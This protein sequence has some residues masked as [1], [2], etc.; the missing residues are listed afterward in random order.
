M[1]PDVKEA[2]GVYVGDITTSPNPD[3][4]HFGQR[5][6]RAF[7]MNVFDIT[8]TFGASPCPLARKS[9]KGVAVSFFTVEGQELI[10]LMVD[11]DRTI[12][13]RAVGTR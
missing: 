6:A 11:S 7:G 3:D 2:A 12:G 13:I 1:L 5:P 10:A 9:V 4:H 8:L